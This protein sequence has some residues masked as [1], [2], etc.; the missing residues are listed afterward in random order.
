MMKTEALAFALILAT[1]IL[2]VSIPLVSAQTYSGFN[3]FTDNIK[4]IFSDENNKV[5]LALEIREK[6]INSAIIN[7]QNGEEDKSIQN[8]EKAREK[9]KIVQEKVSLGT[10]EEIKI[11]VDA[12]VDKVNREENLSEQFE[13]YI[14]EEEKTQLT[15]ELTKKTY[16]YCK[17]LAEEGYREMLN[18]EICN[19]KTAQKGLEKE[20]TELKDIQERMFVQL[21]LEI[22]RCIDDPGTCNCDDSFDAEQKV[23]CEK[24]VA[25]AIKCEY[26]GDKNSCNE[27]ES[28]KPSPGDGFARSFVPDFLINLFSS[29]NDL[30]EYDLEHSDG[31][32][33]ECW[34][35]NDKPECE[36]YAALKEDGLDWDEYGNY[37]GTQRGK[38]RATK[39]IKEPS[40]PSMEES[41]PQCFDEEDNFLK[42]KCGKITI[43]WNEEGLINYII[44]KEIDNILDRLENASIQNNIDINGTEGRTAINEVKQEINHIKEQ[45]AER[46]FA[47]GTYDTGN[48]TNDIKNIVVEG[49]N[50]SGDDGLEPEVRTDVAGGGSGGESGV[51][52]EGGEREVVT[53]GGEEEPLSEPDLNAINPDLY[54]PDAR[55]PGDT[56]DDPD[57]ENPTGP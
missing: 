18:E 51:V 37:I 34:D 12:V 31:V 9:L 24:I 6:E 2:L 4:L 46:T 3:R 48:S 25:L 52:V 29:R 55:A 49:G 17:K 8:L 40:I 44:E 33:E 35:E 53:G 28:M 27:F 50:G 57:G 11:S 30:I 16:E 36:K 43:V 21:M 42:E 20:L 47:P 38:I 23:K 26:K 39:G 19:P 10:S 22:R 15:A 41:I 7:A 54:D 32:P 13:T 5:K 56:I 14:L 45:I 1:F